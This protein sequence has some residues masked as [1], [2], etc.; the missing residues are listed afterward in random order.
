M[1]TLEF[2]ILSFKNP[3]R[4]S[5]TSLKNAIMNYLNGT[6]LEKFRKIKSENEYQNEAKRY[7]EWGGA[8]VWKPGGEGD[9]YILFRGPMFV[10][11]L[12]LSQPD[13]RVK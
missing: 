9:R 4:E 13:L 5:F 2:E 10:P 1:K 12:I 3:L 11:A 7:T 6:N 8:V